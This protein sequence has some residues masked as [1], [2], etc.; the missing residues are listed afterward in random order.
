MRRGPTLLGF[1][2]VGLAGAACGPTPATPQALGTHVADCRGSVSDRASGDAVARVLDD[3]HDAAAKADE[4]RY[5]GHFAEGGVFLGTDG[6]ERWTVP[7]F[8]AYAHP[9]F[10]KGRAWSFR[11][12][13]REITFAGDAAWFDE[14]LDT[15]N[16]G[17]ARGTGVL[18]RDARGAWK[19]AHYNLSVPIPNERFKAVKELIEAPLPITPAQP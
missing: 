16:L 18:V 1:F 12:T 17:P 9:H 15:P 4:E 11:A 3:W 14:D 10:A 8:R 5:F 6:T 7:A 19:I 2:L 13:R